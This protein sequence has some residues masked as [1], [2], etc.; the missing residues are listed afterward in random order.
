M[1]TFTRVV[2]RSEA[3]EPSFTVTLTYE[4]RRRARLRVVLAPEGEGGLLL[5]RGLVL[6][7]GDVLGSED[8]KSFA[9]VRAASEHVS[10]V[11]TADPHLLTRA[12]YHLGNRHVPLQ[13]EPERLIYPHDHVLDGLC[14]ELGVS[15]VE[16]LMPFEP[17][18][19][20]YAG[21]HRHGATRLARHGGH[22]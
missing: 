21:E 6:K 18:P 15:V 1:L 8:G 13:I 12:A 2:P 4:Q 10:V 14:R 17:E 9:R 5:P 16:R 22:G 11:E 19:G 20:G 3:S 7:D